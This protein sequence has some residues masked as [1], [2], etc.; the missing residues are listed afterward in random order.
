[1]ASQRKT[2]LPGGN[3][4]S[5]LDRSP[6]PVRQT[7]K[8]AWKEG[9]GRLEKRSAG[10]RRQTGWLIDVVIIMLLIGVLVGGYFLYGHLRDTYA[11][12]WT[13]Y[14]IQYVLELTELSSDMIAYGPDGEK[15]LCGKNI[16]SSFMQDSDQL[17][18]VV[19]VVRRTDP[20]Q[21]DHVT[22]Y[23]TVEATARYRAGEGYWM[24]DTRL[25][26][27]ETRSFRL[28]G[29]KANGTILSLRTREELDAEVAA[30]LYE[31]N[32]IAQE[33]ES[34]IT[35]AGTEDGPLTDGSN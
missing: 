35:A 16:Y 14:D 12:E 11:P 23:V 13:E 2:P 26:C 15:D 8:D 3:K 1:M 28:A 18:R 10:G 9:A 30:T 7:R 20:E 21:S 5:G 17:G 4:A 27:G 32:R 29:L 25:L 22:L 6:A 24:A 33:E 19:D 34:D 31:S